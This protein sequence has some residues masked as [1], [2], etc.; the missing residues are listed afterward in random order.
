L[1]VS[2]VPSKFSADQALGTNGAENGS[3]EIAIEISFLFYLSGLRITLTARHLAE[4]A[5]AADDV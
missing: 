5:F 4:S 1:S 2:G 3:I